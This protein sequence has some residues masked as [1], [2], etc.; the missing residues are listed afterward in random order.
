MTNRQKQQQ[1]FFNLKKFKNLPLKKSKS[2]TQQNTTYTYIPYGI[3][4]EKNI[5]EDVKIEE[6]SSSPSVIVTKIITTIT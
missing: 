5:S 2:K 3:C 1:I 6:L 4:K